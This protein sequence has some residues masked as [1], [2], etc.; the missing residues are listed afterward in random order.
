MS[1]TSENIL[2][3]GTKEKDV[4]DFIKLLGYEFVES[5]DGQEI[6]RIK[7]FN[8]FNRENYKSWSGIHLS[9]YKVESQIHV[10]TKTSI[11]RSFYDLEH[12]N[13]TIRQI[14]KYFKGDF[15]TDYGKSRYLNIDTPPPEHSQSGC[16]LAFS[17]FGSNLI[18]V[19]QYL[20]T[21]TFGSSNKEVTGV[22]WVDRF[23]PKLLSNILVLP[24][25]TSIAEDYWK[26]TFIALFKYCDNKESILKTNRISADRLAQV[27]NGELSIE[28]AYAES[29]SFGRISMVCKHIKAI[30]KQLDLASVLKKPYKRRKKSLFDSLE[31]ITTL[32]NEII[33]QA[34][35]P[36]LI[37][38]KYISDSFNM[39]HDSIEMCYKY[40]T[41][42]KGWYFDKTWNLGKK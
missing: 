41:T 6:G 10:D 24:F 39:L 34:S 36:I 14:R 21:R 15:Y 27:S 3:E 29:I 12:H 2:P 16:H 32:R 17:G 4:I 13:N 9:V 33:H 40:I 23:N 38:D 42:K 35:T 7:S 30:D 11:G 22:Y 28:E 8:W 19:S 5:W 20:E 25:L 18:R 1:Y 31:E 37:D 26:S